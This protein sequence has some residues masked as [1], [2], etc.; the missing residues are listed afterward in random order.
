MADLWVR[1]RLEADLCV[2]AKG[3][4]EA[5]EPTTT[6]IKLPLPAGAIGLMFVYGTQQQAMQ[7]GANALNVQ[8]KAADGEGLDS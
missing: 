3:R 8:N 6:T 7:D 1:M 2:D 5:G 4:N